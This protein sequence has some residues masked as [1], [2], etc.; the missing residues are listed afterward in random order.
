MVSSSTLLTVISQWLPVYHWTETPWICSPLLISA[1]LSLDLHAIQEHHNFSPVRSG[2]THTQPCSKEGK[3]VKNSVS[4]DRGRIS[5]VGRPLDRRV[6][7]R[8]FYTLD[9]TQGLKTTEKWRNCLCPTNSWAFVWLGW[10]A[11]FN[12]YLKLLIK[13]YTERKGVEA[14]IWSHTRG[15]FNKT[16]TNVIYKCSH[17]F[18][19][20]KQ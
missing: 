1:T 19:V 9:P 20:S 3:K 5:W 10:P 4:C 11:T 8:R 6:K 16:F 12:G 2:N 14:R 15:Q 18:R 13:S 17:C 7:G